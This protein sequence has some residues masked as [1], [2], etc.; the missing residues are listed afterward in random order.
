MCADAC[1]TPNPAR[2]MTTAEETALTP[3]ADPEP[4]LE[5]LLSCYVVVLD[6]VE[7]LARKRLIASAH[8][9]LWLR[10]FTFRLRVSAWFVRMFAVDHITRS[11]GLI[12]RSY[13]RTA[14]LSSAGERKSARSA[15]AA[16]DDLLAALPK[17]RFRRTVVFALVLALLMLPRALSADVRGHQVSSLID[18][19]FGVLT[20]NYSAVEK[21]VAFPPGWVVGTL[22]FTLAF[23]IAIVLALPAGA[24]RLKR[25]AFAA[26]ATAH[27]LVDAP[28]QR[29]QKWPFEAATGAYRLERRLF[30]SLGIRS[31]VEVPY[32]LLYWGAVLAPFAVGLLSVPVVIVAESPNLLK[33]IGLALAG[34]IVYD[35]L[36]GY[37]FAGLPLYFGL[38]RWRRRD[39]LVLEDHVFK[40]GI[41]K[42]CVL[43]LP[44]LLVL[45]LLAR[46]LFRSQPEV[47]TIAPVELRE[48]SA[49]LAEYLARHR[50]SD[51]T[52]RRL[53][54]PALVT[55]S[56]VR[57]AFRD[58]RGL[59][60]S[61]RVTLD[62]T[63]F[64]TPCVVSWSLRD[65]T[66]ARAAPLE[67]GRAWPKAS[68]DLFG[69]TESATRET[70]IPL[71]QRASTY[72]VAITVTDTITE[73]DDAGKQRVTR[74]VTGSADSTPVSVAAGANP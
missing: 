47:L 1:R 37:V 22:V 59:V 19:I 71:P 44:A 38:K 56:G 23:S 45:G 64:C 2:A 74:R 26:P 48:R 66:D 4:T 62:G 16:I 67:R 6:A 15:I 5:D 25:L 24:F 42:A 31:T 72:V 70:W 8:G 68:F 69:P 10:L 32:D 20:L 40:D 29:P 28:R 3:A 49:P 53:V 65:A 33:G 58:L 63:T 7:A 50:V 61:Y 18:L 55:G 27:E 21:G 35:G 12:R 51:A 52:A 17:V 36:L 57:T 34:V 73:T 9:G 43:A 30:D 11:L 54:L 46:P 14:V 41:V 13:G 39:G 60:V